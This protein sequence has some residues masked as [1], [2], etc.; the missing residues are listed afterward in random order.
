MGHWGWGG[1]F[2]VTTPVDDL[3]L[4]FLRIDCRADIVKIALLPAWMGIAGTSERWS[5]L[6]LVMARSARS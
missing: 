2:D 6:E 3:Y 4:F 5:S 1:F